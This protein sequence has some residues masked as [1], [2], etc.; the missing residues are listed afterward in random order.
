MPLP[1]PGK[2]IGLS[3]TDMACAFPAGSCQTR[4][5][6]QQ[7]KQSAQQDCQCQ[8]YVVPKTQVELNKSRRHSPFPLLLMAGPQEIGPWMPGQ[9]LN[10]AL[11]EPLIGLEPLGAR[12]QAKT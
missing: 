12:A 7:L 8:C 1:C 3:L 4:T 6:K 9:V 5:L 2:E 11:K 10:L